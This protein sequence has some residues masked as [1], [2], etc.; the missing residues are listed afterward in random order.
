MFINGYSMEQ[1]SKPLQRGTKGKERAFELTEEEA[2]NEGASDNQN[3]QG[4]NGESSAELKGKRGK[5]REPL[6]SVVQGLNSVSC[7][8][9]D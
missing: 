2:M 7:R 6:V 4:A 9:C 8:F 3:A 5:H 1:Y